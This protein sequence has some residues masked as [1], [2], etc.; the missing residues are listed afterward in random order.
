MV[1]QVLLLGFLIAFAFTVLL[2]PIVRRMAL[3]SGW[4]DRPDG[5][6]K[7]HARTIPAVGGV[8][9]AG[10]A[11]VGLAYLHGV[12]DLVPFDLAMPP[13]MLLI[14]AAVMVA[15]GFYDDTRGLG[16]K[17]KFAIQVFAAYTLLYAGYRVD[18]SGLPFMGEDPYVHAL[19]SIPLTLLWIVGVIN[20]INLMDGL[21]G[22]AAGLVLIA[23]ACLAFVFGFNG[24]PGLV[25]TALVMGGALAGFLLYNFNPALIFMGDSGSM[26]L[27]YM[28]ATYALEGRG[29]ADPAV[30]LLIPAV[31]LGLPLLDTTLSIVR[32]AMERRAVFAPDSDH[33]HHRLSRI[34][35]HRQAVLILYGAA[36]LFGG[37][38]V[39]MSFLSPLRGLGVLA[40]VVSL[41]AVGI[42]RLKYLRRS[43]DGPV[44]EP[45]GVAVSNSTPVEGEG[46][47]E[48]GAPAHEYSAPSG[49]GGL[50]AIS[51]TNA[52]GYLSLTD[53]AIEEARLLAME[54][55][56]FGAPG[57][58]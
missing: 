44:I 54:R 35:S 57:R 4:V 27:G 15:A 5:L 16:F 48:Y 10:G 32:R 19:L 3:R 9:I 47:L 49:D 39:L 50:Q 56:H 25:L 6:R 38:A 43:Y 13:A 1:Y 33:I 36:A 46:A 42:G 18:V 37:A 26:F 55:Q 58:A 11:A 12:R 24:Q 31:A 40:L 22:L 30:A 8:A 52:D 28:L 20:A 17:G 23:F 21:D 41:A 7:L 14:G 45:L 34:W 51:L 29:H 53:E 2:T